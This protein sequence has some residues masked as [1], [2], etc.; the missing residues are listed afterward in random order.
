L[1]KK[2]LKGYE[3]PEPGRPKLFPQKGINEEVSCL[4]SLNVLFV[5]I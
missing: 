2:I 5:R 4:K 3:N 1:A